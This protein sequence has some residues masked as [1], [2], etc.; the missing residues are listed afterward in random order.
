LSEDKLNCVFEEDSTEYNDE[1]RES[2]N[3]LYK[4]AEKNEIELLIMFKE[5]SSYKFVSSEV[6]GKEG[7]QP[8]HRM[9]EIIS[10]ST[11]YIDLVLDFKTYFIELIKKISKA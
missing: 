6:R 5:P 3:T 8:V 4:F 2:I 10:T 9:S 11:K 7:N 1:I